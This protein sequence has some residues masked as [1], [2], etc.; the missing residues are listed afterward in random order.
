M[1]NQFEGMPAPEKKKEELIKEEKERISA[2]RNDSDVVEYLN[3]D[4]PMKAFFESG[5]VSLEERVKKMQNLLES[6]PELKE[7]LNE[8]KQL[9]GK[10]KSVWETLKEKE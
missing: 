8:L 5:K 4:N 6:K 9:E 1:G 7:K 2:L 3:L 10:I